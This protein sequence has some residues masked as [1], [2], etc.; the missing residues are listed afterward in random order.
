MTAHIDDQ[1]QETESCECDPHDMHAL[2]KENANLRKSLT[3]WR[4]YSFVCLFFVFVAVVNRLFDQEN[5]NE[6]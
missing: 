1:E 2:K 5:K 4:F 3:E 6:Q